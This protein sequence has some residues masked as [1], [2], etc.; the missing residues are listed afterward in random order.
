MTLYTGET[1]YQKCDPDVLVQVYPG[2]F[3]VHIVVCCF[4]LS[5][6]VMYDNALHAAAA[7]ASI[8]WVA[9]YLEKSGNLIFIR[10]KSEK[11]GK[12]RDCGLPVLWYRSCD[13][14]EINVTRVLLS[15][16]DM[17]KMDCK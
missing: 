7:A 4:S 9:T 11:L 15:E 6:Y 10:E 16:V 13:S 12:V 5:V 17:H 14:Y 1:G 2:V 3:V 8:N